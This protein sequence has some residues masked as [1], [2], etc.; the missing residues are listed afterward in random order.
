MKK[1]ILLLT[2]IIISSSSFS[3]MIK[4]SEVVDLALSVSVAKSTDGNEITLTVKLNIKKGWHLNANQPLD[5]NLIPTALKFDDSSN[6]TV[7]K[8]TYP[9]AEIMKIEQLSQDDMALYIDQATITV[10]LKM[11]KTFKKDSV[12]ISG[13]VKYQ[14]CNDQ[15]CLFPAEKPFEVKVKL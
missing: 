14:P 6:Y 5:E 13:K 9:P 2:A 3:Q 7:Q 4:P 1:Y 12:I 15:M 11:N 8:I 10:V